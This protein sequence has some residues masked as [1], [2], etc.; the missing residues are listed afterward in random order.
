MR[1]RLAGPLLILAVLIAEVGPAGAA[2]AIVAAGLPLSGPQQTVGAAMRDAL[3]E[4]VAA[5]NAK[6]GVLGARLSLAVE[7][8]GCSQASGLAAATKLAE[9]RPAVVIGHSCSSAAIAAAPVYAAA[10][11]ILISPGARHPALTTRRAGPTIFRLAGRDDLQGEAAASWLVKE[12]PEGAIAIVHDRTAYAR[13]AAKDTLDALAAAGRSGV[14][15]IPITAGGKDYTAL[16]AKLAELGT[17]ALFFAGYP[18]EAGLIVAALDRTAPGIPV[19]G[20]DSIATPEFA[21]GFD[22]RASPVYAL[23]PADG[24]AAD[25]LIA[26]TRA[27]LEAWA[28]AAEAAGTLEAGRVADAL[29]R[30]DAPTAALGPVSFSENGDAR[31]AS[32]AI[33]VRTRDGWVRQ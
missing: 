33:A 24:G 9:A 4:A 11:L 22:P 5:L 17:K 15:V 8:D 27:A 25:P 30:L 18:T 31:L 32:Y 23:M 19:L 13:A 12:A 26:R 14:T 2:E 16:A 7:D 20:S 29:A 1:G 3:A 21:A 28:L 6:G 10:G